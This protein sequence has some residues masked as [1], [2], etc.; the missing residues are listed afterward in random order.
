[1]ANLVRMTDKWKNKVDL[2]VDPI[3][4]SQI[5]SSIIWDSSYGHLNKMVCM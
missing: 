2:F 4:S 1:M 5:S 3:K